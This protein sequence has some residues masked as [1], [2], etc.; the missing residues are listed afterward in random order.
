[1]RKEQH[2]EILTSNLKQSA[3]NLDL[4]KLWSFQQNNEPNYAA[5]VVRRH[6]QDNHANYTDRPSQSPELDLINNLWMKLKEWV[7]AW[8]TSASRALKILQS[9]FKIPPATT[10]WDKGVATDYCERSRSRHGEV[11]Y[12]LNESLTKKDKQSGHTRIHTPQDD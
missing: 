5:N 1:M 8:K 9:W 3:E 10:S 2:P 12:T 7:R 4:G 11:V 6:L